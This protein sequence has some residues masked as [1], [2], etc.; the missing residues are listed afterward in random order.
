MER[1]KLVDVD[2]ER[3]E[4]LV[5][6]RGQDL[7]FCREQAENAAGADPAVLEAAVA[8]EEQALRQFNTAALQLETSQ[9]AASRLALD[10]GESFR[11]WQQL[12]RQAGGDALHALQE[13]PAQIL[14]LV[15]KFSGSRARPRAAS[16]SATTTQVA[17]DDSDSDFSSSDQLHIGMSSSLP[18]AGALSSTTRESDVTAT[19]ARNPPILTSPSRTRNGVGY[20]GAATPAVSTGRKG[21]RFSTKLATFPSYG[22]D[23][24][25]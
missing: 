6:T 4:A 16:A 5:G 14:A 7:N 24:N 10:V 15:R 3:L 17:S 25:L 19:A 20:G 8:S 18:V 21:G 1:L 11:S 23:I 12:E 9:E 2:V 13:M 22:Y